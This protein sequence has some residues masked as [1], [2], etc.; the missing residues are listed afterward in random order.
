M[1]TEEKKDVNISEI[2]DFDELLNLVRSDTNL[3]DSLTDDQVTTLRTKLNPYGRTI[4]GSDK[5]SCVSITNISEQYTKRFLMTSLIGFLYRRCD[6]YELDDGEPPTHLDDFDKFMERYTDAV[7]QAM[8]AKKKLSEIET[9]EENLSNEQKS[10]IVFYNKLIERGEGFKKRLIVRQFLNTLFE[11]NP[12]MHVR[13]AYADN[14]LDPE[15]VKPAQIKRSV[16]TIVGKDG[17]KINIKSINKE[18]DDRANSQ[19]VKH[20]PPSDTFHRWTY[21]TDTNYEEVRSAVNDIY[22]EKPD[23]EFA[24]NPYGQF[25]SLE[26]AEKFVQKHKSEVIA[27]V[28]TLTNSKWNLC[29]SFKKN[30]DRI[31]F[32]N[33]RTAVIEEIFK[34]IE[35]DKKLGADLMRKRVKNKKTK[36]IKEAGGDPELFSQYKKNN[37]TGLESLGAEDV[38][39]EKKNDTEKENIGFKVHE[40]CPYNAVQVDVFD[41]REGGSIVNKSQFFTEAEAPNTSRE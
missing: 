11:Y 38:M 18:D 31:N 6:E 4:E 35:Q 27:D 15:R 13:S 2:D 41:M 7:N 36:N 21:Y 14:P 26:E 37:S 1:N 17:S 32:Y 34:Q 8:N 30:R 9:D 33:E 24:I 23:L 16:K 28:L 12:D 40:E 29:G 39:L 5:Y 3:V 19:F 22:A 10:Q 25:N 20:I